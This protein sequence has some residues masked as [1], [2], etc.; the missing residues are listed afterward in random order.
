MPFKGGN[1]G[2]A[3]QVGRMGNLSRKATKAKT[4]NA[5]GV[6]TS[7]ENA[8]AAAC[9]GGAPGPAG[10]ASVG[11]VEPRVRG[12]LGDIGNTLGDSKRRAPSNEKR[13]SSEE[14]G[15]LRAGR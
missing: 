6:A 12:V 2:S 15:G 13:G 7:G 8:P 10:D 14:G 11:S 9:S 3:A 1:K 5:D 4:S